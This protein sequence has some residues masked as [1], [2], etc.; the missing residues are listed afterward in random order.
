[1]RS[2]VSNFVS[3]SLIQWIGHILPLVTVPYLIRVIGVDL[4]GILAVVMSVITY[5]SIIVNYGFN[6]TAVTIVEKSVKSGTISKVYS[7]ILTIKILLT[8]I[9]F[10]TV[11][12]MVFSFE[13][14]HNNKDLY[15][16]SFGLVAGKAIT[17]DWFFLGMNKAK[18]SAYIDIFSKLI[19]TLLILLLVKS[20]D[21]YHLVPLF[22]SLGYIISGILSL[23]VVR[24]KFNIEFKIQKKHVLVW[25]IKQNWHAFIS[26]IYTSLYAPLG[27]ILL[28]VMT[29]NFIVGYYSIAEKI[30]HG[31][32]NL[33]IPFVYAVYPHMSQIS[34]S[35][36]AFFKFLKTIGILILLFSIILIIFVYRYDNL[37]VLMVT[38][39][40]NIIIIAIY[41]ILILLVLTT[42]MVTLYV[43]ALAIRNMQEHIRITTRNAFF[44]AVVSIPIGIYIW[45]YIG[46]SISVVLIQFYIIISLF[47]KINKHRT[48]LI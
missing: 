18:Y 31:I 23:M 12:M 11:I 42:P 17:A 27:T 29:N 1:M 22:T 5:F 41:H 48:A 24:E 44:L 3:L 28:G 7:S 43:H 34:S 4:F 14:F 40:E 45:S 19:F 25:Y 20:R 32:S 38:G 10:A 37:I 2:I 47:L 8:I 35:D 13:F 16:L 46:A 9:C 6:I 33:L 39:G 26:N 36:K 21:D 15:L 30:S